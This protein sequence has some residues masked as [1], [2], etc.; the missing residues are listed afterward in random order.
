LLIPG[1]LA[2]CLSSCDVINPEEGVPAYL[3]ID[4]FTFTA[5]SGQ[6]SA[7]NRITDVWAFSDGSVAGIFE[8]PQTFP[9]LDSGTTQMVLGAGIW[10][11]G[12]SETRV[13]Y[14]FYYPDTITL[15]L[16]PAKTYTVV[17]HFT[18]RSNTK[19]FFVED[20]EAGNIFNKI[21][22]DT[23]IIRTDNPDEV[24][25]GGRSGAIYLDQD[26]NYF[27]GETSAEYALDAG[28]P[29]YL[30]LNYR[31]DQPFQVGLTALDSG[32][33]ATVYKWTI[34][35][36]SFWN[37][38]YLNMGPD[39]GSLKADEYRILIKATYDASQTTTHVYLDNIKL[40][41]Y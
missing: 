11:N 28:E 23:A 12:I 17:P 32:I 5:A 14:P 3:K 31:C 13:I 21:D 26:H 40:V 39:V 37:K 20:F 15:D 19:F 35:P 22:G 7:S 38:I 4:T 2:A 16:Q 27:E 8:L 36:K 34:N 33:E 30:E 10:D 25:E 24:F 29:V 6:G 41:S 9:V 18:Y 1:C